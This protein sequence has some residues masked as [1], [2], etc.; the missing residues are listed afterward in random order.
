MNDE[1]RHEFFIRRL[2]ELGLYDEDSDYNGRIARYVEELSN[3][4]EYQGHS[5][6]SASLTMEVFNKLMIEYG[7]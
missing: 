4:F 6:M 1:T 3:V 5:V 7:P 2:K